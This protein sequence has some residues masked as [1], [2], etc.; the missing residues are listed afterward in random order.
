MKKLT[1]NDIYWI[2]IDNGVYARFVD[3]EEKARKEIELIK[4]HEIWNSQNKIT[5]EEEDGLSVV[6][7]ENVA[8]YIES[9]KKYGYFLGGEVLPQLGSDGEVLLDIDTVQVASEIFEVD[10]LKEWWNWKPE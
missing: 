1:A 2:I 8:F 6:S 5:D 9:T 7:E 4:K 3:T 10:G